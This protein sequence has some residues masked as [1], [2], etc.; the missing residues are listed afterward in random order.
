MTFPI[1]QLTAHITDKIRIRMKFNAGMVPTG[2]NLYITKID[3]APDGTKV[4]WLSSAPPTQE[5]LTP[6]LR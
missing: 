3:L 2:M 6:N 4:L 5:D 1:P